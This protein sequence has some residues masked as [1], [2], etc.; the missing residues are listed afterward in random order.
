MESMQEEMEGL[1]KAIDDS[2]EQLVKTRQE[3]TNKEDALSQ[4][5]GDSKRQLSEVYEMKSV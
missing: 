2:R 3:L 5:Q 1:K 4:L